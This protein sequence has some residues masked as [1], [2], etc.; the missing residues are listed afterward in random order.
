[1]I[2]ARDS[3]RDVCHGRHSLFPHPFMC[4]NALATRLRP[5]SQTGSSMCDGIDFCYLLPVINAEKAVALAIRNAFA[6]PIQSEIQTI[7]TSSKDC[8]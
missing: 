7:T 2:A 3:V 8:L 6:G 4:A 1:M 5:L